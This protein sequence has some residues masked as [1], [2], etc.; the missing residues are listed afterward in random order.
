M[1]T[2]K[3]AVAAFRIAASPEGTVICP[4]VMKVKGSALP[5]TPSASRIAQSAS[6]RGRGGL[7]ARIQAHST[8]QAP[9]VRMATMVCTPTSSR[10]TAVAV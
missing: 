5:I 4:Q 3:I 6:R 7:L 8:R 1:S 9:P 10:A 2:P